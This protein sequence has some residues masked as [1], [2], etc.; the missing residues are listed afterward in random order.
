MAVWETSSVRFFLP[1]VN[2]LFCFIFEIKVRTSISWTSPS[3]LCC[4][5]ISSDC[6]ID[7]PSLG[8]DKVT[9]YDRNERQ[10]PSWPVV[11]WAWSGFWH[12]F[13]YKKNLPCQAALTLVMCS[14]VGHWDECL[15]LTN[16][17]WG[18]TLKADLQLPQAPSHVCTYMLN[19]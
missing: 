6:K 16:S 8:W 19:P 15:S 17:M 4:W 10:E 1:N 18:M 3:P 7:I 13:S 5:P 12:T 11:L 9:T 14:F 2:R